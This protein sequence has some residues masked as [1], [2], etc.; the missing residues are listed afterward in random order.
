MSAHASKFRL[1]I[2]VTH[3]R[4]TISCRKFVE[5]TVDHT[6]VSVGAS[7]FHAG[8]VS[9]ADSPRSGRLSP[10]TDDAFV[11]VL[12]NL[13]GKGCHIL[14]GHCLW[15]KLLPAS[16]FRVLTGIQQERKVTVKWIPRHLAEDQNTKWKNQC[17]NIVSLEKK[18]FEVDTCYQWILDQNRS[19]SL[20]GKTF[21]FLFEKCHKYQLFFL[22][23]SNQ[24]VTVF[25]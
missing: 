22:P 19:D 18:T 7:C 6:L 15:S 2:T 21:N 14:W 1:H 5:T 24:S 20:A 23:S 25:H 9:I 16:I 8:C 13:L 10:A 11:I 17:W 4:F 12:N 3:P